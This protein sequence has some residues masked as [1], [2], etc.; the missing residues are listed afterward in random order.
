MSQLSRILSVALFLVFVLALGC[1]KNNPVVS[2][3]MLNGKISYKGSPVTGGTVKFHGK[4][5]D[6][7]NVQIQPDGSYTVNGVPVGDMVVTIDTESINPDAKLLTE[8]KDRKE[9]KSIT[10]KNFIMKKIGV[11]AK[12]VA[13]A[14]YVKIPAKYASPKTSDLKVTV[15]E[16]TQTQNFDLKD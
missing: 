16:G 13:A 15:A 7:V 8:N 2:G 11:T 12:T 4:D 1:S 6:S 9:N 14:V 5:K 3:G 10:D